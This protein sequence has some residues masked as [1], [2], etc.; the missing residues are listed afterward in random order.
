M[1]GHYPYSEDVPSNR[2]RALA[3]AVELLGTEGLRALTH[4]RVDERAGLPKGSTSN[5]FRTRA[6]LLEGVVGWMVEQERPEVGAAALPATVDEL[7]DALARL[8]DFMVGPN[9]TVTTARMVLFLEAAHDPV[10]RAALAQGRA[11][12]EGMLLPALARLGAR[13]PQLATDALAA[14]FEGLFLHEIGR[15]ARLDARPVLDLVV[16]AAIS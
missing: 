2:Q 9:R 11:T 7:V 5:H 15:H 10:L 16:R 1:I 13:D 14:C 6:A 12:M 4:V 8:F 3:A